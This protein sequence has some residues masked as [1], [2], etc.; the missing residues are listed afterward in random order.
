LKRI[1]FG[2]CPY[3]KKCKLYRKGNKVCNEEG[4]FYGANYAGCVRRLK[5]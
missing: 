4:G 5:K 1:K 2:K 3:W